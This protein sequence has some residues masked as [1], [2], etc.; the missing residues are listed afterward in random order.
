MTLEVG[1]VYHEVIVGQMCAHDVVFYVFL[2]L[3]RNPNVA[4]FVHDVDGKD[5]VEAVLV[6]RFQ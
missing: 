2:V 1:Q 4:V 6:Y 3:H 5:R